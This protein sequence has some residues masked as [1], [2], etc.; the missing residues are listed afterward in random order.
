MG[1]GNFGLGSC[2]MCILWIFEA[3][4]GGAGAGEFFLFVYT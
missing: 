1:L 2:V 3:D 4:G